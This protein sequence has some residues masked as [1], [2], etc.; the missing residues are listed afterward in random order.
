MAVTYN[1]F[2]YISLLTILYFPPL[3]TNQFYFCQRKS[4]FFNFLNYVFIVKKLF[5]VKFSLLDTSRAGISNEN[6]SD[7]N[8]VN[9]KDGKNN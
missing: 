6:E 8:S 2:P 3:P 1:T 5:I 9:E 7:E 4:Q